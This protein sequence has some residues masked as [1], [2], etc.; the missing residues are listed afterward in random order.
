MY[1][2]PLIVLYLIK[3]RSQRIYHAE[4]RALNA[5]GSHRFEK[6]FNIHGYLEKS[7]KMHFALK[8]T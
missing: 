1:N 2:D 3:G 8:S 7:L 4:L 6:Y 5:Q